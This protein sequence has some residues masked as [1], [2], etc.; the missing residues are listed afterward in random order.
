MKKIVNMYLIL[1]KDDLSISVLPGKPV[2]GIFCKWL[3][4]TLVLLFHFLQVQAEQV[5]PVTTAGNISGCKG[6]TCVAIPVTVNGYTSITAMSLRMEFN[7]AV[8]TFC[9]Y[10][11]INPQLSGF[12]Y[13]PPTLV[14]GTTYKLIVTSTNVT[15]LTLANGAKLFDVKF[16]LVSGNGSLSFNNSSNGGSDCEYANAAGVPLTD[17]PTANFYH[18][19]TVTVFPLPVPSVS[20]NASVCINNMET[21]FTETGMTGYNWTINGGNISSGQGTSTVQ[22]NWNATGA[23]WIAVNYVN[24]SGCTASAPTTY[25]VTV[26]PATVPGNVS[27]GSTI[28]FGYSTDSL[29]LNGFQGSIVGWQK[30]LD[31]G[32]Y[33]DIPNTAGKSYYIEIPDTTGTWDYRAVV[34]NGNCASMFS[35]PATVIVEPV[36]RTIKL[37]LLLEGLFNPSTGNMNKAQDENGDEFPG[38]VADEIKVM[39]ARA[40]SPYSV[41]HSFENADLNQD[42]SCTVTVPRAGYYYLVIRHRN[43][44]ETWSAEP[45][46]SSTDTISYD[47]TAAASRA[48]GGNLKEISGKWVIYGGDVNQDGIVDAGDMNPVDNFSTAVTFGYVPEDANGDGI[49]DSGDMNLV[50]NNA[51]AVVFVMNP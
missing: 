7:S 51:T 34:Q 41:C 25:S 35:E 32:I 10:A 3:L 23:H 33:A 17:V 24:A 37:T 27:G 6:T 20:G 5:A 43:S 31:G 45:V 48:F 9:S 26:N 12:T 2:S 30:R 21:Y 47:F 46:Y 28:P 39:I 16:N 50:D 4:F 38:S 8:M 11:S 13:G 36:T 49:V 22:V 18:N 29:K 1:H 19:A 44:I 14:S 15:P 42:G 40:E